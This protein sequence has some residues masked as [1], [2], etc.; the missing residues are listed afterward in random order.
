MASPVNQHCASCVGTLS[1]PIARCSTVSICVTAPCPSVCPCV[2]SIDSSSGVRLF[3]VELG[4]G[5]RT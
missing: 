4:R 1:F 2:P 3:A 5:Q